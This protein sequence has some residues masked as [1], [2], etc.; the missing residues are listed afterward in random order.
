MK[1]NGKG[2]PSLTS[3]GSAFRANAPGLSLRSPS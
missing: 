2:P 1:A 3:Y